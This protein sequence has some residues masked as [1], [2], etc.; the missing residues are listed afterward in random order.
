MRH[1]VIDVADES[2]GEMVIFPVDP[3]RTRQAAAQQRQRF[4]QFGRYFQARKQ[5]RHDRLLANN[6]QLD[7]LARTRTTSSS[8]FGKMPFTILATPAVVGC[9]PSFWLSLASAAIPSRKNG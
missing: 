2:Q 4:G 8:T 6:V 5:S 7:D 3:A 1:L 9:S